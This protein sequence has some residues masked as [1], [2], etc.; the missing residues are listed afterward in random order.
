MAEALETR[1]FGAAGRRP[2]PT[3]RF[4]ALDWIIVLVSLF[5][6]ISF[7]ILK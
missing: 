4:Q 6:L 3:L 7:L 1:G 2:H 5:G